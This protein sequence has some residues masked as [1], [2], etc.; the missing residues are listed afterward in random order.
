[1]SGSKAKV[2]RR[3]IYGK[4]MSRRKREYRQN[5]KGV[6]VCVGLRRQYQDAEKTGVICC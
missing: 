4:D 5:K 3:E 6:I 2:F 1:M